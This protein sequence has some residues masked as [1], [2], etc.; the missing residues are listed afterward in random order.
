MASLLKISEAASLALHTMA[1]FA[2][3][4]DEKFSTREIAETLNRS[5]NHLSK[6]LQRLTR[7]G[8]IVSIRGPQGGF[9]LNEGWK[10][11]SFLDIYEAIEGPVVPSSCISGTPV[12]TRAQ[13][14]LGGLT[15]SVN[16]QF[17]EYMSQTLLKDL[18]ETPAV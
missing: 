3:K 14:I 6:V 15:D 8:F 17:V 12:C 16:R 11:L 1:L 5:E 10:K 2:Q 13:C 4:D 18:V 9:R 7:A